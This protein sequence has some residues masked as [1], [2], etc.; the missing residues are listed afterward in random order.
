MNMENTDTDKMFSELKDENYPPKDTDGLK[1]LTLKELMNKK[2][3]MLEWIV[4]KLVPTDSMVV[5][6][7]LSG[8]GKTWVILRLALCVAKGAKLFDVFPTRQAGVLIVDEEMGD[9]WLQERMQLLGGDSELPVFLL[10]LTGFKITKESINKLLKLCEKE[11]IGLIIFDSFIRVHTARDEN[12]S[13]EMA[14]VFS[15][16]KPLPKSGISILFT[17][18]NR[19]PVRGYQD[20]PS[21]DMRGS[22]DIRAAVDSQI[23]VKK[24]DNELL[25]TQSKL[26]HGEETPPFTLKI[27]SEEGKVRLE[28]VGEANVYKSKKTNIK[29]AIKKILVETGK[30]MYK[31]EIFEALK[32]LGTEVGY[33]TY[34][35]A[36][37]EMVGNELNEHKGEKNTVYLS[38]KEHGEG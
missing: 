38:L 15:L 29:D 17:Q 6:S 11:K 14:K 21:Q 8:S 10:S 32:A 36:I 24:K 18:H 28:Y 16:L 20:D 25:I 30:P 35:T 23:A 2:F 26:R 13:V 9:R 37:E 34:K 22:S 19:K 1:P 7:G 33:S 3:P 5:L 12:D 27:I 31:R 4:D